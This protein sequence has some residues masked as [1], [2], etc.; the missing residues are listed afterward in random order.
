M[1]TP[2]PDLS[3]M[4]VGRCW[5]CCRGEQILLRKVNVDEEK[6]YCFS[7][8]QKGLVKNETGLGFC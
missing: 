6:G 1:A 4:P 8:I 2:V 3:N 7:C 5:V